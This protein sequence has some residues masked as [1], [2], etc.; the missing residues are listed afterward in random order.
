MTALVDTSV[1]VDHLRGVA[2]AAE[3]L[4][5]HRV[6]GPLHGSEVSRAE[7]LAGMRPGEEVATR[8]LLDILVWHPVDDRV[9]EEAGRLG[10][11]WLG[12]AH[13]IDTADLLVAATARVLGLPLLT[14]EVARFPTLSPLASPS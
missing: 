7:I 11:E 9:A 1:L 10:R 4:R 13:A 8:R 2:G 12:G 6:D 14:A 3:L 5:Q